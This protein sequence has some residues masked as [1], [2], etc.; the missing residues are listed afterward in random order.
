LNDGNFDLL[1]NEHLSGNL[2]GLY[3]GLWLTGSQRQAGS[4]QQ[5]RG[6]E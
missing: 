2:D 3:D 4:G 5:P 1:G 6:A